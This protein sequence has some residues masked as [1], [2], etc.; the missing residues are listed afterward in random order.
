MLGSMKY[1]TV[2][3]LLFHYVSMSYAV[4]NVITATILNEGRG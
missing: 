2:N 4:S 1:C 3:E